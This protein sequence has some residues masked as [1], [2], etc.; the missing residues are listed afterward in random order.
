[1]APV[2]TTTLRVPTDLRD[3][4]ARLAEVKGTTMLDVVTEAV[5]RLTRDEWW[6]GVH[7][8]IET[9]SETDRSGYAEESGR[10]S[11]AVADGLRED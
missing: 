5:G 8:A 1:M 9:M 7:R 2:P 11:G 10:L 4:I 6:T 3:E